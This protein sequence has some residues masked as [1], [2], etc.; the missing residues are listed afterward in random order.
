M[1]RFL[2]TAII[3]DSTEMV[4]YEPQDK[5]TWDA[6]FDKYMNIIANK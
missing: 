1:K 3:A 4:K 5:A 6:A 2:L